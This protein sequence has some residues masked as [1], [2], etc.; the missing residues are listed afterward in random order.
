MLSLHGP[1]DPTD[2][3][4]QTWSELEAGKAWI[5]FCLVNESEIVTSTSRWGTVVDEA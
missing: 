1:W 4:A 2:S 3:N 5:Q